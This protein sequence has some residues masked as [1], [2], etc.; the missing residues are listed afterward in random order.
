[1]SG[2]RTHMQAALDQAAAAAA[3]GEVPVGA[4]IVAPDGRV[5]A[6]A[7]NRTREDRDPTAHA[8]IVALRAACARAG[9][10]RLP[11]HVIY[12][13]LEP[14]PMCAAAIANARIARL[15]YAAPDPKSGGVVHG[16]RVFSHPQCHHRPEVID[17]IDED[18][19][20][21]LLRDFFAARRLPGP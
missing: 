8:E 16:A 7:G 11:G 5:V 10:D 9:S 15:V 4:V 19:A 3:R 6:A 12:V 14:C 1:M 13:T 18:R 17:G 2:F 21:R 20:A